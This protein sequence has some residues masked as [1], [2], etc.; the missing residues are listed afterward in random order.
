MKNTELSLAAVALAA[1]LASSAR[2]DVELAMP[3]LVALDKQGHYAEL[4]ERAD[5]VKP[6]ARSADWAK[7]VTG[8]A[9]RIVDQ[10]ARTSASPEREAADL[11]A[12]VPPA[13]HRY[14]F[15]TGDAGYVDAKARA[16]VGIAAACEQDG[17]CAAIAVALADGI[18]KLP[19]RTARTLAF[20]IGEE[21]GA[22]DAV[23]FWALAIDGDAA[24]C[25][26]PRL[27]TAIVEALRDA[28]AAR[29]IADAQ[30]AAVACFAAVEP[31][32]V[33]Q[34]VATA[35][36][37]AGTDRPRYLVNACPVLAGHGAKT[38]VKKRKCP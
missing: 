13:E 5:Q 24:T 30:R 22:V 17:G 7:L 11:L 4:L 37:A 8:A 32:L 10:V 12:V 38:I 1:A 16:L 29:P 2:G 25:Q 36:P 6:S 21:L 18:A 35:D 19:A 23:H 20:D 26:Q 9:T 28:A 27:P 14:P 33:D 34:L 3:D 31:A 15:L